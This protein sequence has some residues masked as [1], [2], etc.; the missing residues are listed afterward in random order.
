M[1][2]KKYDYSE[3]LTSFIDTCNK[4]KEKAIQSEEEIIQT[5]K[6][7]FEYMKKRSIEIIGTKDN[8]YYYYCNSVIYKKIKEELPLDKND[9]YYCN[10]DYIKVINVDKPFEIEVKPYEP[11]F[12]NT[13]YK[14]FY[15]DVLKKN[16]NDYAVRVLGKWKKK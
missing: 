6:E 12:N 14:P 9:M 15:R 11:K 1:N 3:D 8:P 2:D 7:A 10:G 13:N 16:E 5:L 4:Q